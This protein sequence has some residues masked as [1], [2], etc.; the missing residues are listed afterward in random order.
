MIDGNTDV[1][2]TECEIIYACILQDGQPQNVLVGHVE[3]E[4]AQ[5]E[6]KQD[7]HL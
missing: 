3:V 6:G 5:A 1:V 4:H 7:V 2:V